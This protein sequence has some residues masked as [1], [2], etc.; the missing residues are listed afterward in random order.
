MDSTQKAATAYRHDLKGVETTELYM[1]KR[2]S[3]SLS[4]LDSMTLRRGMCCKSGSNLD[5]CAECG[6][7]CTVGRILLTRRNSGKEVGK[8]I[9]HV[10]L[11]EKPK[12]PEPKMVKPDDLRDLTGFAARLKKALED[13][14]CSQAWLAQTV[15]TKASVVSQ[16]MHGHSIPTLQCFVA[17]CRALDTSADYLLGVEV[18][19]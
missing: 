4:D 6:A 12:K 9:S 16:W 13:K 3:E 11:P 18:A 2:K 19:E 5:V 7:K 15:Y 14:G 17:L 8:P 1:R 10:V